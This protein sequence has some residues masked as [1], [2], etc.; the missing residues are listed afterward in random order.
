MWPMIKKTFYTEWQR[1]KLSTDFSPE[2]TQEDNEAL[3]LKWL[4]NN[5]WQRT[6]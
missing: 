1:R 4:K 5:C 2:T 6:L 3:N